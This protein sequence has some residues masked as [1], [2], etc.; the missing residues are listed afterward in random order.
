MDGSGA[1]YGTTLVGG[2]PSTSGVGFGTV[3]KLTPP[4]PGQTTGTETVLYRFAG[5]WDGE[6]PASTLI[7]DSTGALRCWSQGQYG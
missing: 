5:G 7:A 3:F 4:G 2:N 6:N 1:L